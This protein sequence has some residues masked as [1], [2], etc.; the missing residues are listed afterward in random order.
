MLE[1]ILV[2]KGFK[3]SCFCMAFPS[4]SIGAT[5]NLKLLPRSGYP[6]KAPPGTAPPFVLQFLGS[7]YVLLLSVGVVDAFQFF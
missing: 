7:V 6:I 3:H 4:T 5:K 1:S 2:L